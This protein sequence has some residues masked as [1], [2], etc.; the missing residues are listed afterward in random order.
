MCDD[1]VEITGMG[2]EYMRKE[3]RRKTYERN[4]GK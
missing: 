2:S 1:N 4:K 3:G